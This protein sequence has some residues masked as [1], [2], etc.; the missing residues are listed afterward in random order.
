VAAGQHRHVGAQ[1]R[2]P[3]AQPDPKRQ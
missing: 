1:G 3:G 2:P